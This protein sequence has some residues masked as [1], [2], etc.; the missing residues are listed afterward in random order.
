MLITSVVLLYHYVS[1]RPVA[2]HPDVSFLSHSPQR[3]RRL[4]ANE[5]SQ[6]IYSACGPGDFPTVRKISRLLCRSGNCC[7]A[8]C[9]FSCDLAYSCAGNYGKNQENRYRC[10]GIW[11]ISCTA[12]DRS[13]FLNIKLTDYEN[14]CLDSP[15][16]S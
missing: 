10:T 1:H 12:V 4:R 9:S 6:G 2:R 3:L 7:K 14:C 11:T 15:S 8:L 16:N 5:V 13:G